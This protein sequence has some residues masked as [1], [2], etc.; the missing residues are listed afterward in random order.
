MR[1]S[2]HRQVFASSAR[3]AE[4]KSSA[5]ADESLDFS[6]TIHP[7]KCKEK[8][9]K[10]KKIK[11]TG[12]FFC[13]FFGSFGGHRQGESFEKDEVPGGCQAEG[14]ADGFVWVQSGCEPNEVPNHALFKLISVARVESKRQTL[15]PY[16][17]E[18]SEGLQCWDML[19]PTVV[20]CH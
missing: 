8:H 18:P 6:S 1:L 12:C 10:I 17:R 4:R 11:K 7:R 13:V 3:V 9:K 5:E 15:V 14:T 20:I 19:G 2:E 16:P